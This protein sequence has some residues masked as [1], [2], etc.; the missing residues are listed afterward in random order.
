MGF[1][2]PDELYDPLIHGETVG[3]RIGSTDFVPGKGIRL[4][5]NTSFV[6][7]LLPQ[8]VANGEFSME[9]EGLRANAPGDKAKVFGM[10]ALSAVSRTLTLVRRSEDPVIRK[11]SRFDSISFFSAPFPAHA[12]LKFLRQVNGDTDE[13][14]KSPRNASDRSPS[15]F[16]ES[17]SL[18]TGLV[19]VTTFC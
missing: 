18:M 16:C 17:C 10:L 7:Y 4:N 6:R 1:N 11:C 9:V 12:S 15:S 19:P 5:A 8:T 13:L 3:D 2:R 14:A